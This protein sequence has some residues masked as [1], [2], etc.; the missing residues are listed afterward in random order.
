MSENRTT[1]FF[2]H[3][4]TDFDTWYAI[5]LREK[6]KAH[7]RFKSEDLFWG[8][9]PLFAGPASMPRP[10]SSFKNVQDS[11]SQH[12]FVLIAEQWTI[13]VAPFP[14]FAVIISS[15]TPK[16]ESSPF[17]LCQFREFLNQ[18]ELK[19]DFLCESPVAHKLECCTDYTNNQTLLPSSVTYNQ[20]VKRPNWN[21][22]I[23]RF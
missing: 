13:K 22:L 21:K 6:E 4:S 5:A 8:Y 12:F 19:K 18:Y 17:Q 9:E 16:V 1:S 23:A 20:N 7:V 15:N 2:L 10:N 14:V 3:C 11:L